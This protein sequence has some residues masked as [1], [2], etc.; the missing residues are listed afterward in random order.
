M[1]GC[2]FELLERKVLKGRKRKFY[3]WTR[4]S[5]EKCKKLEISRRDLKILLESKENQVRAPPHT[6][7]NETNG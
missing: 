5:M 7:Y 1:S 4:I 3:M 6:D 2:S